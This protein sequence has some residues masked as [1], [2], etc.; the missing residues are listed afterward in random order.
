M[1]ADV[2]VTIEIN[3]EVKD[4]FPDS[5]VHTVTENANTLNFD[6]HGFEEE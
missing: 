1:G 3:A 4:G 5:V 6:Q 2:E